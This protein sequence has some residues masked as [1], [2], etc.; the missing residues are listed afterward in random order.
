MIVILTLLP[1]AS[2]EFS[3]LYLGFAIKNSCE[4]ILLSS[5]ILAILSPVL[6]V[7]VSILASGP[8][9]KY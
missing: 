6:T 7:Y 1:T 3:L 5:L 2:K 9:S 8:K 4:F